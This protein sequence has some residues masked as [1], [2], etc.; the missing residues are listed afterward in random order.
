VDWIYLAQIGINGGPLLG[1][2]RL[3]EQLLALKMY[4]S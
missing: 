1:I 3:A 2:Y 4:F